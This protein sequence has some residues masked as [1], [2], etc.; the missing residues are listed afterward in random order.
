MKK[1]TYKKDKNS[2]FKIFKY[3]RLVDN[4]CSKRFLVISDL[5]I[6]YDSDIKL[7]EDLT[8]AI[9][10]EEYDA[11]IVAGDIIDATNILTENPY[12]T[13]KILDFIKF[14]GTKSPT[15]VAYGAHDIERYYENNIS[16]C[17]WIYDA[18]S[19]CDKLLDKMASY[20]NINVKGGIINDIG[21]NYKIGIINPNLYFGWGLNN[22]EYDT[23]VEQYT[24]G[25]LEYLNTMDINTVICHYPAIIFKLQ[26]LGLLTNVD[27][28]VSGHSHNGITQF[29]YLPV[30]KIFNLIGMKNRGLVPT[31]TKEFYFTAT[32][33][34]RGVISLNERT[35]LVINPTLKTISASKG[36]FEKFDNLFYKSFTEINYISKD[37]LSLVRRK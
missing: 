25:F 35:N 13:S 17:P 20:P 6:F 19:F 4:K 5:H 8:E 23:I 28:C 15:F 36:N 14:L 3:T 30:E 27:L 32:K 1:Y 7:L 16:N 18:G 26:E 9:S 22:R 2:N 11:I 10:K 33:H 37:D 29:K 34:S 12:L 31:T 24:Y 21:D